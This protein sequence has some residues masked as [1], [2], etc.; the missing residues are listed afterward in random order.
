MDGMED[1]SRGPARA[2]VDTGTGL[3]VLLI[4]LKASSSISFLSS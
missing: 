2:I 1:F 4:H 3:E